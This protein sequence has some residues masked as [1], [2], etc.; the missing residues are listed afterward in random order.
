MFD[1]CKQGVVDRLRELRAEFPRYL[2]AYNVEP[3][4]GSEQLRSHLKTLEIRRRFSN[5]S[6]AARDAQFT[7]S[8]YETL[9]FW[10][11]GTR[12]FSRPVPLPKFRQ[13][14]SVVAFALEHLEPTTTIDA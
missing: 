4:F 1:P 14:F 10:G 5:P 9:Q 12:G 13:E 7:E 11:I 2:H 3:P 6:D 8:L